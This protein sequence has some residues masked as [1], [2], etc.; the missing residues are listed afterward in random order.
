MSERPAHRPTAILVGVQ[1]P[2]VGDAEHAADLAELARLVDTLGYEV[3]DTVTQRRDTL[4]KSVVLGEGKLK[5]LAELTGGKGYVPSAV[6][7]KKD[8]ARMRRAEESGEADDDEFEAADDDDDGQVPI[9]GR[10]VPEDSKRRPGLIAVDH[11][12]GPS[13]ARNLEKATGVQVLDRTGVILEIFHRH[14]R[15]R[16]AKLQVELA[17]LAYVSPRLRETGARGERQAGRGAG[18]TELELD[19]R[20]IRDRMAEI[21]RELEAVH[22]EQDH[23]REHRA[24]QPTVALVGYT[25]AGKSSLM[26]ALTGSQVLVADQLFATLDTTIRALHPEAHPRIL[27]SDTVGFIKKLPHDLV[28]SFR[29]TLDE[30]RH[31]G[32]LLFLVDASDPTFREQYAVT[33]EVIGEIGAMQ[34]P[35]RLI[36][37]K[38]DRLDETQREE[39][40]REFPEAIQMSALDKDDV[41]RLRATIVAFFGQALVE[42]ELLVPW[43]Q[44]ALVAQLHGEAQ[45]LSEAHEEAGTRVRVRIEPDTLKRVQAALASSSPGA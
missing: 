35:T 24:G 44:H 39:L 14:A 1:L 8:K 34:A 45:V 30:A 25:N 9:V 20:R 38:V 41:A 26:R 28:A 33:R 6:P 43:P 36:L 40:R 16:E 31:A 18:E 22:R 19:R 11:E 3:T 7:V 32:L 5:E 17:R 10:D 13:Q 21:R 27:V 4:S 12:L 15:S 23:R 37:N 42:A 2:G 29:S